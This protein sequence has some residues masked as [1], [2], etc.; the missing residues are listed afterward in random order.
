MM[1]QVWQEIAGR[2]K[3]ALLQL[4][5][6]TTTT[7]TTMTT[8][9]LTSVINL[10]AEKRID[11]REFLMDNHVGAR[12]CSG[13]G[14]GYEFALFF[15]AATRTVI[16]CKC[17][18]PPTAAV[19]VANKLFPLTPDS[20]YYPIPIIKERDTTSTKTPKFV[21]L[22]TAFLLISKGIINLPQNPSAVELRRFHLRQLFAQPPT[23]KPVPNP[24]PN[25]VSNPN[26]HHK[27]HH[28]HT[29]L[30]QQYS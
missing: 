8:T 23:H 5:S 1:D 22:N 12:C 24:V 18:I 13:V 17:L 14:L 29:M 20:P 28:N 3:A 21:H 6:P 9:P 16:L 2:L 26:H 4:L 30:L 7:T 10:D 11:W 15:T 19:A 25:P 27:P